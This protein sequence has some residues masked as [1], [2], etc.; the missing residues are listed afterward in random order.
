MIFAFC[1]FHDWEL[2][3][4]GD[5]DGSWELLKCSETRGKYIGSTKRS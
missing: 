1:Q 5:P 2:H 4:K 3:Y